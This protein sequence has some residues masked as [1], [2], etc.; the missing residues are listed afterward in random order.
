M[1]NEAYSGLFLHCK[2]ASMTFAHT[3][4]IHTLNTRAGGIAGLL[5]GLDCGCAA[6]LAHLLHV[7][8]PSMALPL[9]LALGKSTAGEC[10]RACVRACV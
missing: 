10:L 8:C 3:H 1:H 7:A 4:S 5:G 6:T 9:A 2:P